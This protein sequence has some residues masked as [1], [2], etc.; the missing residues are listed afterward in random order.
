MSGDSAVTMPC[1]PSLGGSWVTNFPFQPT[2]GR[3]TT[4]ASS[5]C[6][7]GWER[8]GRVDDTEIVTDGRGAE[9]LIATD[10]QTDEEGEEATWTDRKTG[11]TC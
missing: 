5:A 2:D 3:N 9:V 1:L 11:S 8:E 7:G 4:T 10:W 6:G